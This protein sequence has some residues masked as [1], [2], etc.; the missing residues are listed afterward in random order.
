MKRLLIAFALLAAGAGDAA[1]EHFST[2]KD[3]GGVWR[4]TTTPPAA[5]ID[6]SRVLVSGGPKRQ[7]TE[8][9]LD[10]DAP[11]GGAPPGDAT[12]QVPGGTATGDARTAKAIADRRATA[13]DTARKRYDVLSTNVAVEWD[14]D[15]DGVAERLDVEAHSAELAKAQQ[16]IGFYCK[17]S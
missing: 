16:D 14:R 2:W 9:E 3:A 1:A 4:Y 5:G 10:V 11:P 7:R 8:A 6:S 15:G 13:C 17:R 12:A